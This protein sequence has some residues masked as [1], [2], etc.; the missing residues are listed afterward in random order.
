MAFTKDLWKRIGGFPESVLLGDDTHFDIEARRL[1]QP[2]FVQSAK[3]IYRPQNTLQSATR[4]LSRYA[5]SDGVL[6]VRPVR[7][8]R[9][10]FRCAL[11]VLALLALP[12]LPLPWSVLPLLLVLA[13]QSW[14]AFHPD[15]RII[16][17]SGPR[18]LLARFLFSALVPWIIT[19]N[20]IHG[21]I[22]RKEPGNRQNQQP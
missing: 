20:H 18:F 3:A 19:L 4:Q 9:N 1:T 22:T 11:H 14:L 16:R 15:W 6:G 12:L 5:T 10:A 7:L 2:A 17:S 21:L 8:V 13:M